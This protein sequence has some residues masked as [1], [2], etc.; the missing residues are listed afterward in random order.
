MAHSDTSR[1]RFR[2][3]P[4]PSL[5]LTAYGGKLARTLGHSVM[6]LRER[7]TLFPE[8]GAQLHRVRVKRALWAARGVGV[9]C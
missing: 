7:N 6:S 4:N 1:K 2:V 5:N 9:D 8:G 3:R